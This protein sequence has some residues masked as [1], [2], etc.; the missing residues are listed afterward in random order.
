[1][2]V[3][4]L[5]LLAL[6]LAAASLLVAPA[7]GEERPRVVALRTA[8]AEP[9]QTAIEALREKL[10][11]SVDLRLEQI[12][13]GD[14]AEGE[15]IAALEPAAIVAVGTRATVWARDHTR[16]TPIVFAMVLNPVA[17]GLIQ[18]MHLPGGRITGAALDVPPQRQL[19]TLH[20]LVGARRIAVLYNPSETGGIV[21]EAQRAARRAG[22]DL[23]PIEVRDPTQLGHSLA[24]LDRSIEALWSVADRTVLSRGMVEQVLLH[25]LD[26][27]LPFMGLSA[28]YVRAGALL[29]LCTS[30]EE[31]GEQAAEL[32]MQVLSGSPAGSIPVAVPTQI[33]VV[34]NPRTAERLEVELTRPV[35]FPLR[36]VR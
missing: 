22:L 14:A 17:G 15:R 11:E 27:Q 9:Y 18:S 29:A 33:D 30:Y 23:V 31:N 10:G 21:G 32:L 25:T 6:A 13:L 28:Q 36:A 24:R 5:R 19:E 4:I 2:T 34:F 3:V 20:E 35:S 26:H 12:E 1:V 16:E 8:D 7:S